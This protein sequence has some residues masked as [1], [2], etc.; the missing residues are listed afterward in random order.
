MPW[1]SKY[2][3]NVNVGDELVFFTPALRLY[4][5]DGRPCSTRVAV[6][7]V[8]SRKQG[9]T[10]IG[11][12]PLSVAAD[13]SV[14]KRSMEVSADLPQ[15]N[16]KRQRVA[17]QEPKNTGASSTEMTA[18]AVVRGNITMPGAGAVPMDFQDEREVAL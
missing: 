18:E 1:S 16:E 4:H 9:R 5:D 11:V 3:V 15:E 12:V 7:K 8:T 6:A 2:Y 10:Y 14:I 13:G 17:F